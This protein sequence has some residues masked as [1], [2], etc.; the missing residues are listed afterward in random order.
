MPGFKDDVFTVNRAGLKVAQKI[1]GPALILEVSSTTWLA[2]GW[3]ATVDD[4]GNLLLF[5]LCVAE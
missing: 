5:S 2:E 4:V 1:K 3:N